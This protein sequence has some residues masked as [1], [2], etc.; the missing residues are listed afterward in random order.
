MVFARFLKTSWFADLS[1][2]LCQNCWVFSVS[3]RDCT[4]SCIASAEVVACSVLRVLMVSFWVSIW[5]LSS[6]MSLST[7]C[8]ST[9]LA[10]RSSMVFSQ[11]DSVS[12]IAYLKDLHSNPNNKKAYEKQLLK[13]C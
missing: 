8:T 9:L 5:D 11:F 1:S 13:D 6:S 7:F 2:S 3:I 12:L 10:F 4:C